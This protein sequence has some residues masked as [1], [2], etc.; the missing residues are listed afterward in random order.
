MYTI[1]QKDTG[2][3]T[4]GSVAIP[5]GTTHIRVSRADGSSSTVLEVAKCYLMGLPANGKLHVCCKGA[6][7]KG[8]F[9]L[10]LGETLLVEFITKE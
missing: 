1:T 5:A 8:A 2:S 3:L 6:F 10:I 9:G 7:T 4:L